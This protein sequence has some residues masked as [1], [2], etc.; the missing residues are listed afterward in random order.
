MAPYKPQR[1][2]TALEVAAERQVRGQVARQ[3][4]DEAR[5]SKQKERRELLSGVLRDLVLRQMGDLIER[6]AEMMG[7]QGGVD[8]AAFEATLY[9]EIAA[10]SRAQ[11]KRL[12]AESDQQKERGSNEPG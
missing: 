8:Q 11:A 9:K 2:R 6:A 10:L 3:M 12:A 1:R 7:S 5:D 4:I